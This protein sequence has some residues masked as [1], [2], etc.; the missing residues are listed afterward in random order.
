MVVVVVH[1]MMGFQHLFIGLILGIINTF[2]VDLV[3][4]TITKGNQ[5][6]F[7]TG[8]KLFYRTVFNIAVAIIISLLIRLID[9]QLLKKNIIT[10][11]IETFR[12]IAYYQI[13]YY[14]SFYLYKKIY[15]LIERKKNE[16][17]S[18]KS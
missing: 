13:I 1:F 5:A 8:L 18:N 17:H 4:L 11:P 9:L 7:S 10:M 16:S 3:I 6:H 2:F 14:G 15:N 12:F